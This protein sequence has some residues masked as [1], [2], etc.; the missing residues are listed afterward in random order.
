MAWIAF[1]TVPTMFVVMV[2]MGQLEERLLPQPPARPDLADDQP[3][4]ARA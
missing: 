3:E 1:A 2:A 4:E